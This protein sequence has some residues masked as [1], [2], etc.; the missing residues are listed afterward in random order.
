MIWDG[1]GWLS[2]GYL[3]TTSNQ[4]ALWAKD[5]TLFVLFSS[6]VNSKDGESKRLYY[7]LISRYTFQLKMPL[8]RQLCALVESCR[9]WKEPNLLFTVPTDKE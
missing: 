4:G 8:Y 3:H 5:I 2:D 7:I 1:T 6:Q 9:T